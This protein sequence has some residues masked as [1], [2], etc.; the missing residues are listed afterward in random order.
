M[1]NSSILGPLNLKNSSEKSD[2]TKNINCLICNKIWSFPSEKDDYLAHLY[3]HHRI[4]IGDVE[5]VAILEDYLIYW[6]NRIK[7]EKSF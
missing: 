2:T 7:G 1:A 6:T 4:V 3:L 5:E